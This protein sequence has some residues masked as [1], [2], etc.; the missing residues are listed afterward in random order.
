M[1]TIFFYALLGIISNFSWSDL[2]KNYQSPK[3]QDLIL[4]TIK[5]IQKSCKA[6]HAIHPLYFTV[7]DSRVEVANTDDTL[8]ES[9]DF[10]SKAVIHKGNELL[11][12]NEDC[13]MLLTIHEGT[14]YKHKDFLH[15]KAKKLQKVND[16]IFLLDDKDNLHINE[17]VYNDVDDFYE[18]NGKIVIYKMN[19]LFYLNEKLEKMKFTDCIMLKAFYITNNNK[20]VVIDNKKIIL[21]DGTEILLSIE[22]IDSE[23]ESQYIISQIDD[24]V[25]IAN[26][27]TEFT[28]INT[29]D[30]TE[31]EIVRPEYNLRTEQNDT[32]DM[33]PVTN[34]CVVDNYLYLQT[35]NKIYVYAN[36]REISI[37]M[38]DNVNI[39]EKRFNETNNITENDQDVLSLD[40]NHNTDRE[41]KN[42]TSM[43]VD[44]DIE[45]INTTNTDGNDVSKEDNANSTNK[46]V[47]TVD[48]L[49]TFVTTKGSD[50]LDKDTYNS[51]NSLAESFKSFEVTTKAT[52]EIDKMYKELKRFIEDETERLITSFKQL[53]PLEY[54]HKEFAIID[55]NYDR[56]MHSL[57][58]KI[59]T[60]RNNS[61]EKD[62]CYRLDLVCKYMSS[63][64]SNSYDGTLDFIDKFIANLGNNLFSIPYESV[65]EIV[66]G[67]DKI[68]IENS[69]NNFL[70]DLIGSMS[71]DQ[72]EDNLQTKE[73]E[74][75]HKNVNIAESGVSEA[76]DSTNTCE[77]TQSRLDNDLFQN[78]PLFSDKNQSISSIPYK[79]ETGVFSQ[80]KAIEINTSLPINPFINSTMPPIQEI[81]GTNPFVQSFTNNTGFPPMQMKNTHEYDTR[82]EN[83][84]LKK[85]DVKKTTPNATSA[86]SK[87]ANNHNRII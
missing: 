74:K 52:T 82:S 67:I 40:T 27:I 83:P 50:T 21:T 30:N 37:D 31:Y 76:K 3:M 23:S 71:I 77:N 35:E 8:L 22:V 61:L 16:S 17:S 80:A 13:Y 28:Y 47:S 53:R 38:V 34:M 12:Y 73:I 55:D 72:Q 70:S 68:S 33:V 69:A 46:P 1:T 49:D 45:T 51:A 9:F 44:S 20:Y 48:L 43:L 66:T 41:L 10:S 84:F 63:F 25:I 78:L 14:I 42:I 4:T 86:L 65:D 81:Q 29:V 26:T 19:Q 62:M 39:I 54:K 5:T 58:N 59:V 32:F 7:T 15:V 24:I 79:H 87:F 64:T 18:R 57:Y 2:E 11:L 36:R 60:V 6:F 75:I 85:S 56:V